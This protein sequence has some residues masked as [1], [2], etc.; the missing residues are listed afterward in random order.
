MTKRDQNSGDLLDIFGIHEEGDIDHKTDNGLELYIEKY[1]GLVSCNDYIFW[2]NVN[3]VFDHIFHFLTDIFPESLITSEFNNIDIFVFGERLPIEIQSTIY[4]YSEQIPRMSSFEQ[5]VEKQIRENIETYGKCWLF[6]DSEFYR[7]LKSH[8]KKDSSVQLDW[9]YRY[10]KLDQLKVFAVNHKG[11]IKELSKKDF[12]FISDISV[13]CKIGKDSDFRI[14]NK[15]KDIIFENVLKGNRFT[16]DYIY[17]IRNIWKNK[18]SI[19]EKDSNFKLWCTRQ[20]DKRINLLGHIMLNVNNL[21]DINDV[22]DGNIIMNRG[23][24]AATVLGIFDSEGNRTGNRIKFVDRINVVQY[25][26]AYIRNKEKWDR[27]KGRWL[28]AKQLE[29]IIEGKVDYFWYERDISNSKIIIDNEE[30]KVKGGC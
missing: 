18:R 29:G 6:F 30:N 4:H 3:I 10:M 11:E 14:L 16:T 9:L 22:F 1:D 12:D 15:N 25:F 8:T 21:N 23:Q 17:N 13:T 20:K 7:Y 19:Q 2:C 26:P 28:T 24:N 5:A 27:H